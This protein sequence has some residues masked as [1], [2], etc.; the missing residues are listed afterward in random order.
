MMTK[1]QFNR[2]CRLS[3]DV[4]IIKYNESCELAWYEYRA[5]PNG[6]KWYLAE[7]GTGDEYCLDE[8]QIVEVGTII[9]YLRK[10]NDEWEKQG[11]GAQGA[12]QERCSGDA[13]DRTAEDD[14]KS[15]AGRIRRWLRGRRL[16]G[17][18][19]SGRARS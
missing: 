5:G 18:H 4:A 2:N 19:R 7:A 13:N 1:E 8:H 16:S 6:L 14:G 9:H 11:D 3:G 12:A 15:V 10:V 17:R